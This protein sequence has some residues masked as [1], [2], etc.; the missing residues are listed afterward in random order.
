MRNWLWLGLALAIASPA[1]AA[2][3]CRFT[4]TPEFRETIVRP[5]LKAIAGGA[6][7]TYDDPRPVITVKRQQ[8]R[9]LLSDQ[10]PN[11]LDPPYVSIA[12]ENCGRG[13]HTVGW[14]SPFPE[15]PPRR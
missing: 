3:K 10:R 8:V 5:A 15:G 6:W 13:A 11:V 4:Y 2:P 9:L 12:V 7:V 1:T 14:V